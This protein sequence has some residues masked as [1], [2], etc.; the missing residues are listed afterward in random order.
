[1]PSFK[2]FSVTVG[3]THIPV[4]ESAYNPQVEALVEG[5]A[6]TIDPT[7]LGRRG[8]KDIT[9]FTTPALGTALGVCG[10]NGKKITGADIVVLT[11]AQL[12]TGG[13]YASGSSHVAITINEGYMVLNGGGGDANSA[14]SLQFSVFAITDGVNDP[15]EIDRAVALPNVS[16][17]AELYSLNSLVLT[18]GAGSTLNVPLQS[19]NFT[20]GVQ[21]IHNR[22]G[23]D[24]FQTFAAK[25][26]DKP[27]P[28]DVF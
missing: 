4:T 18:Y 23:G 14:A 19:G 27:K 13:T 22:A 6:S 5:A 8:S 12:A 7:A 20:T 26:L 10:V 21:E 3:S 25:L 28:T 16:Q 11:Y 15:L 24:V 2:L 17:L 1:M 9:T